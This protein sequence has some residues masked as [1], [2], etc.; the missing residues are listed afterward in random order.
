MNNISKECK[1]S[2]GRSGKEVTICQDAI[3][4]SIFQL[5]RYDAYHAARKCSKSTETQLQRRAL[6]EGSHRCVGPKKTQL[7]TPQDPGNSKLSSSSME[8]RWCNRRTPDEKTLR[9]PRR[10]SSLQSMT[11]Q[12]VA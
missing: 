5:C 2:G 7:I 10:P 3:E 4:C 11:P 1:S 8:T 9:M 12:D 6:A